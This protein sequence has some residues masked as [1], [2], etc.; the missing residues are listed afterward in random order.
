MRTKILL[1]GSSGLVG[2]RFKDLLDYEIDEISR[3][4][5]T[6]ITD[7]DS[8]LEKFSSS[9][10]PL[11]VH[12][13]AKAD[14]DGC[15]EDKGIDEKYLSEKSPDI[16]SWIKE[17]T[18]WAINVLGTKNV[19]DACKKTN[20]KLIYVSTDFVFDGTKDTGYSEE[21]EENPVN[22]YGRTKY[23]GEKIVRESGLKWT[24]ARLAY[25]YRA[26]FDIKKDFFRAMFSRL[27]DKQSV[28]A[29]TNH[30]MSPTFIDDF[31][32]S[33][34][35]LIES[36][37]EGIFHTVGSQFIT[38]FEAANLIAEKFEL[39]KSLIFKTTRE[40]Y[41]KGKAPR[42]FFL[43]LKNDKIREL[44]AKLRTFEEGLETIKEEL[45]V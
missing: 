26:V 43:G 34:D 25:P 42:P 21:D 6:D 8:L 16:S 22:W 41:F 12:V 24:V 29:I 5:G 13:A 9:D 27:K 11:V 28:Y 36:E 1:T 20:K 30:V 37:S 18:A 14:V 32:F 17:Q 7:K 40:E 44:G 39:D 4:A 35:K 3:K 31:V 45:K 38:P 2:S 19:V 10:A 33:I 15:E 23:E